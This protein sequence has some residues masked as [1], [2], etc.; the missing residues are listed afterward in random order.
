MKITLGQTFYLI[1]VIVFAA[2]L[3]VPSWTA[4]LLILLAAVMGLISWWI[5]RVSSR[6]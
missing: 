5:R 4:R 3:T 1:G 6:Q 2:L